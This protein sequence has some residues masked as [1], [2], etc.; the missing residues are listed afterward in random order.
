MVTLRT[1]RLDLVAATIEHLDAEL[2]CPERLA[3]LLDAV[4]PDGW[5]PG[6]YDRPAIEF[7]RSRLVENPEAQGWYTW[8]AVER[9]DHGGVARLVGAG[10]YIGPPTPE[11]ATEIGS[12]IVPEFR[13]RG[14]ATELIQALVARAFATPGVTRVL[15]HTRPGNVAS[16]KLLE[17]CGFVLAGPGSDPGTVRYV[18]SPPAGEGGAGG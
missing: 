5:P 2:L 4:V 18:C 12:S 8:Y 11:G 3:R 1:K 15:A 14:L 16:V 6:E 7:F 9:P 13:G 17:R 10:G